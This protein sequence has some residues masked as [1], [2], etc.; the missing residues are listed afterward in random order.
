MNVY[1]KI[2]QMNDN[3]YMYLL[4]DNNAVSILKN[5]LYYYHRDN[6]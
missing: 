2:R 3:K 5:V 4:Y 6:A 1:I